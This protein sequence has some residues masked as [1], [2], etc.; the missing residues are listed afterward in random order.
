MNK[1]R[2]LLCFAFILFFIMTGCGKVQ[3]LTDDETRL[4]AEYAADLL[5][6]YDISYEDRISEG[7]DKIRRKE[8]A[9]SEIDIS[10]EQISDE[11]ENTTEE[12]TTE[13][14]KTEE[15]GKDVSS[16]IDEDSFDEPVSDV[17]REGDI[18][19][20]VGIDGA[21]ITYKDFIITDQYPATDED[22]KFIYLEASEGYQLLVV[23]FRVIN[24][25]DDS[26][27]VS[28]M[29]KDVSYKI[30]CNGSKAANPMLTILMD[31]LGTLE[32]SLDASDEQEAVLV[33]QISNS[34]KDDLSSVDLYVNYN[35]IDNVI[36]LQ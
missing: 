20:L 13:E 7:D 19:K 1:K 31:D 15:K 26:V 30:V 29:D 10:T 22:G 27:D 32:T 4:I 23:R 14:A 9:S 8:E 36:T 24:N 21:S 6:K 16:K 3:D 2:I 34:L 35:N 12:I 11:V 17:K 28:M 5:L 33:F 18:A 25:T